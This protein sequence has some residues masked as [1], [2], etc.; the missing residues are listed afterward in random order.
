[1]SDEIDPA[2]VA[3]L[4]QMGAPQVR[5]MLP[6]Y[7]G[8]LRGQAIAW[9]RQKDQEAERD[10][11]DATSR[12]SAA[13]ER[14]AEAA[15]RAATAAER[16]ADAAERANRKATT[17]LAIATASIIATAVGIWVTHRDTE[18]PPIPVLPPVAKP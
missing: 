18:H 14:A 4:E 17:A 5:T 10:A 16:Q 12:A 15:E 3:Q 11:K 13:A 8:L 9:L 2:I 6:T 1:M 7:S